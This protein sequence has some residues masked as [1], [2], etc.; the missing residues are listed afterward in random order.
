ME[1]MGKS[2]PFDASVDLGL[3]PLILKRLH[4]LVCKMADLVNWRFA[5]M[6]E[7]E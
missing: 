1:W 4:V 7:R 3:L 5:T 6:E 2:N